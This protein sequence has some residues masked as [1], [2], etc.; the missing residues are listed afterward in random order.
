MDNSSDYIFYY[1]EIFFNKH[2]VVGADAPSG[3]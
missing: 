1:L 2:Y 3:A